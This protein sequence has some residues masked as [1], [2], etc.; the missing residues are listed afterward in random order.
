MS[1]VVFTTKHHDGFNMFDTKQTDF[2]ISA[3]PFSNNPKA[4]V[5]KYVFEAFRKENFMIG[6]I[7]QNPTGIPNITGGQNTLRQTGT[8]TMT[9]ASIH[10]A[11]I[12]TKSLPI[13]SSVN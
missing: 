8:I 12:N 1:Y 4:N 3:G 9:F 11:G 2:K 10:G 13:T 7:F 5:A 6:L